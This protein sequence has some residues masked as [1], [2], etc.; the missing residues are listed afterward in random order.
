MDKAKI[1][2]LRK[3]GG[4]VTSRV[5]TLRDDGDSFERA[6]ASAFL[7]REFPEYEAYWRSHVVPLIR[8]PGDI[9]SRQTRSSAGPA[10]CPRI[11]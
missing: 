9:R 8:R 11:S 7:D 6:T 10:T 5:Y 2:D 4:R 3:V 1:G